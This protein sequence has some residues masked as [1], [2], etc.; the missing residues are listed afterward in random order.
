MGDVVLIPF[1]KYVLLVLCILISIIPLISTTTASVADGWDVEVIDTVVEDSY[2]DL[3]IDGLGGIHVSYWHPENERLMYAH[4]S[5]SGTWNKEVVDPDSG[6]G[7]DN[8][9]VVD[10]SG[11]VHIVYQDMSNTSVKYAHKDDGGIWNV[12]HLNDDRDLSDDESL[13]LIMDDQDGLHVSYGLGDFMVGQ[14][15]YGYK[16]EGGYWSFTEILNDSLAGFHETRLAIGGDGTVHCMFVQLDAITSYR[17][18]VHSYKRPGDLWEF[19][20]DVTWLVRWFAP[21]FCVGEDNTGYLFY[22]HHLMPTHFYTQIPFEGDWENEEPFGRENQITSHFDMALDVEEIV[23]LCYELWPNELRLAI[24]SP[25]GEWHNGT[26][27]TSTDRIYALSME[28][29][30]DDSVHIVYQDTGSSKLMYATADTP[31]ASEPRDVQAVGGDKNISLN[32]QPPVREGW[33]PVTGYNI[34]L[35]GEVFAQVSAGGSSFT[36]DGLESGRSYNLYIRAVN[37][38]GPGYGSE[39]V[40]AKVWGSPSE[41]IAV[42]GEGGDGSVD[43]TW[44]PPV[45]DGGLPLVGYIVYR[46]TDGGSMETYQELLNVISF[47]DENVNNGITYRYAISAFNSIGE[48]NRSASVTVTPVGIP[49]KP[50]DVM[51]S[52]GTGYITIT[53]SPPVDD[54]GSEVIS[55]NIYRG[56]DSTNMILYDNI[57]A[58]LNFNDTYVENGVPY[59]YSVSAVNTVG[60]G[61]LSDTVSAVPMMV[62]GSPV[63][64]RSVSGDGYVELTWS[65]PSDNGSPILNYKIYRAEGL[66][67]MALLDVVN[68]VT[69]YNDASITNGNEYIYS[70]SAVNLIGEGSRS[71]E[72]IAQPIGVPSAPIALVVEGGDG[73]VSLSWAIPSKDGGASLTS[74]TIYKRVGDD[75]WEAAGNTVGSTTFKDSKVVNGVEY[76]YRVTAENIVGEGPPS[77]SVKVS[78]EDPEANGQIIGPQTI[79]LVGI[80]IAVGVFVIAGLA[81]KRSRK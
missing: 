67:D 76:W 34:Y 16:P 33:G 49:G 6:S 20:E 47:N 10:S 44:E 43:I 60:E 1:N 81:L 14:V 8:H 75:E 31:R 26:I 29:D 79:L 7:I 51:A 37:Y 35:E 39:T 38:M 17:S 71:A 32:W 25:G 50:V 64:L 11:V 74:Y 66:D 36:V 63:D 70:V 72:T 77:E 55:Y 5:P 69:N 58:P 54:G 21:S 52:S 2:S 19:G 27:V 42:I 9:I 23:Y 30:D 4:R 13:S 48:G 22:Q 28:L 57:E 15:M 3:A 40:S 62:P 59:F 80:A 18:I 41:P 65:A 45:Y 68:D 73:S 61:E 56:L 24:R 46:G 12:G 53:W 78:P